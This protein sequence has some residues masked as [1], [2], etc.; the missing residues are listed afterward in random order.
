LGVRG[1]KSS[2]KSQKSQFYRKISFHHSTSTNIAK[3][4]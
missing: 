1:N 3:L 2:E 4:A